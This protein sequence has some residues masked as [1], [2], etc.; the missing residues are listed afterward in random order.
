MSRSSQKYSTN[1]LAAHQRMNRNKKKMKLNTDYRVLY[2]GITRKATMGQRSWLQATI[3]LMVNLSK[4]RR[5]GQKL[6]LL[7]EWMNEC[8]TGG[9]HTKK[10][11]R[12]SR[13]TVACS[14]HKITEP[15][16]SLIYQNNT[17]A[18]SG[19][20]HISCPPGG[21]IINWILRKLTLLPLWCYKFSDKIDNLQLPCILLIFLI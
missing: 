4:W 3:V 15:H 13:V 6:T 5:T 16:S 17:T 19:W 11:T 10:L 14:I 7:N 20:H 12:N 9:R 21:F 8:I 1:F 2:R 18:D